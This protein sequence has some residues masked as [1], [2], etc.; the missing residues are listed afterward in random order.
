ARAAAIQA[1]GA[2]TQRRD[3]YSI[4]LFNHQADICLE[5]DFTRNPRQLLDVLL[6]MDSYGGTNFNGA[7]N[8]GLT[9]ME[10]H[11]HTDQ[12]PVVIFLSDGEDA[13]NDGVMYNLCRRSLAK[14]KALSFHSVSFGPDSEI[15]PLQRMADIAQEVY[16]GAPRPALPNT[17]NTG[18]QC[19][20][21]KALDSVK[22]TDTF[23]GIAASLRKPRAS[24]MRGA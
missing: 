10:R 24:L 11:W 2:G 5:N 12:F 21:S 1:S 9:V 8:A 4:I 19:T 6:R 15:A 7:L 18:R 17:T 23:L 20:C 3:S 13:F 22:L 14:G 16:N